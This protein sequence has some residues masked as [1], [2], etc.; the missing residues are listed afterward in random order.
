MA[1][2]KQFIAGN[3]NSKDDSIREAIDLLRDQGRGLALP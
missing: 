3:R 1:K 2:T